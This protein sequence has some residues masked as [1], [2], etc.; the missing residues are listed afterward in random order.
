MALIKCT[1]CGRE[2]SDKANCCV[3]CGCPLDI[4]SDNTNETTVKTTNETTGV[5][6]NYSI[7]LIDYL[8][9][10][11]EVI[12]IIKNFYGISIKEA[13]D[14]IES[15]PCIV[16]N[17]MSKDK[18]I[19]LAQE[20]TKCE[21]IYKVY[22]NG[23]EV[24]LGLKKQTVY[25]DWGDNSANKNINENKNE[26]KSEKNSG[27]LTGCLIPL[28]LLGAGIALAST[29]E[30]IGVLLFFVLVVVAIIMAESAFTE[31]DTEKQ[32]RIQD[33]NQGK[34]EKDENGLLKCP[35]CG[36]T[37]IQLT[38]RGY[39]VTSGFIGSG[40]NERVCLNCMKKL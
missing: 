24:N 10:R 16:G 26:D 33:F 4:K 21:A 5:E 6:D 3:H 35:Y 28:V 38:K 30:T 19:D 8:R 32:K 12:S 31:N 15:L 34:G 17:D 25:S 9:E 23:T 7:E 14:K 36:S 20:L 18:A 27:C 37:Q 11:Y 13:M 1:E 29:G 22:N 40:Q 39:K 2:V